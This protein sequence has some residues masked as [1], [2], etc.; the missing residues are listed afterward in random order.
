MLLKS[1][2][3][4]AEL[5]RDEGITFTIIIDCEAAI[6]SK[7]GSYMD[8]VE[9]E[10]FV[11]KLNALRPNVACYAGCGTFAESAIV[12]YQSRAFT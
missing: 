7:L 10:A 5:A 9:H 1:K 3:V 2:P 8:C 4:G 11:I 6:A 12:C